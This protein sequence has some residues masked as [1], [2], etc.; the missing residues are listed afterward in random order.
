MI[1][2]RTLLD[3]IQIDAVAPRS[4]SCYHVE[5]GHRDM[6]SKLFALSSCRNE[7][8][9]RGHSVELGTALL[10]NDKDFTVIHSGGAKGGAY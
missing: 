3:A 5:T 8:V 4:H 10:R 9:D 1:D 2:P 7:V 6:Q